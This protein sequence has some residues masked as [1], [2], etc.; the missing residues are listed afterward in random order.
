MLR[1]SDGLAEVIGIIK[2]NRYANVK[3]APRDVAYFPIFQS[4]NNGFPLTFEIRH[5]GSA[6]A[7]LRH[8][9][10]RRRVDPGLTIFSR[11]DARGP[12]P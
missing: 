9:D 7:M 4:A 3:D 10:R 5:S 2:D 8:S 6:A 11:G 1:T 12:H